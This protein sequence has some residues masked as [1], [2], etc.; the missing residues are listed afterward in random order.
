MNFGYYNGRGLRESAEIFILLNPRKTEFFAI[1]LV[2]V[3]YLVSVEDASTAPLRGDTN[4]L[5][6]LWV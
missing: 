4:I 6:C 3:E 2:K 1:A 5:I